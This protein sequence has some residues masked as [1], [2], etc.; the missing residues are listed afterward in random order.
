[1][2]LRRKVV[3]SWM[4]FIILLLAF[5]AVVWVVYHREP[6]PPADYDGSI[7]PVTDIFPSLKFPSVNGIDRPV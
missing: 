3:Y 6:A 5:L 4:I 7:L 2:E 1:M